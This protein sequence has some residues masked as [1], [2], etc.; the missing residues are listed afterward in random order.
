MS[1]NT[2]RVMG[3]EGVTALPGSNQLSQQGGNLLAMTI[4]GAR[5]A[6]ATLWILLRCQSAP[7]GYRAVSDRSFDQRRLCPVDHLRALPVAAASR[8]RQ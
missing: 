7:S 2:S 4:R 8:A 3:G 5:K 1:A 6:A